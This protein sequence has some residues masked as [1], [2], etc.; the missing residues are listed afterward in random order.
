MRLSPPVVA[1]PAHDAKAH[2]KSA[3]VLVT[4]ADVNEL[5]LPVV[6]CT[7]CTSIAPDVEW[8]HSAINALDGLPVK[9]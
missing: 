2:T 1:E 4:T 6:T 5:Q 7:P 9:T 8:P 3:A